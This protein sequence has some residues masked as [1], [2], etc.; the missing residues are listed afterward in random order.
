MDPEQLVE[1]VEGTFAKCIS[2]LKKK[3]TDYS[4]CSSNAFR[5]FTYVE[6]IGITSVEAGILVRLSDKFTRLGNLI[7]SD[8]AVV[9]EKMEDTIED[10]INYLAILHSYV[11]AKKNGDNPLK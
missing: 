3:N 2:I 4:G 1:H 6:L 5:N 10:A 7:K 11:V 9:E 8:P